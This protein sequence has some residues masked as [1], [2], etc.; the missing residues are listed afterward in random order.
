MVNLP[1]VVVIV[2]IFQLLS[3]RCSGVIDE[4]HDVLLFDRN[5]GLEVDDVVLVVEVIQFVI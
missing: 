3:I 5:A 1:L 4:L 2:Y